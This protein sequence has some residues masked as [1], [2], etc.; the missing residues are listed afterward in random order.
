MVVCRTWARMVFS[1]VVDRNR[2]SNMASILHEV[3]GR[4]SALPTKVT[5]AWKNIS[6]P[7]MHNTLEPFPTATRKK[8]AKPPCHVAGACICGEYEV[9]LLA[10]YDLW[11]VRGGRSCY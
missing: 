7:L 8:R 5:P 1:H 9:I 3:R 4:R 11:I 6:V 2:V 10:S